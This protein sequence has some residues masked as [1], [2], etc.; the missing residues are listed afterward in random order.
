[1]YHSFG[2]IALEQMGPIPNWYKPRISANL[3]YQPRNLN[4][5]PNLSLRC[6]LWW[7]KIQTNI[8]KVHRT[9]T[10]NLRIVLMA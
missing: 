1:M 2:D 10:A 3:L 9:C 7:W 8:V 6:R 5:Q 4:C